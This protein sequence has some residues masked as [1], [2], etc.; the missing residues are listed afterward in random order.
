MSYMLDSNI[1]IYIMKNEPEKVANMFKKLHI[2]DITVSSIALSELAFGVFKSNRLENNLFLLKE[3]FEPI[4]ILPYDEN[5]AYHYGELRAQLEKNGTPIG[6]LDTLIAAHALSVNA[7][8]VTNNLK[9]FSR[10]KNLRCENW[11]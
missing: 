3:F 1:C 7:I 9:E 6:S 5:A 11:V 4:S 10:I 8:L 2:G